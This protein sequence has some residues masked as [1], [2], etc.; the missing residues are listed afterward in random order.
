[1][2]TVSDHWKDVL[3]QRGVPDDKVSVV[4]NVADET[5]FSPRAKR[6]SDSE[7]RLIYHGNITHRY[8]LDLA[9][10]A[11]ALV[12]SDIPEIRLTILGDGDL[13]PQLFTLR[14]KL[15]L[16]QVVE[17]RD[18]FVPAEDLPEIIGRADAGIVPY[19]NDVFTDGLL[20]TKLM[21]YAVMALPSVAARTTAIERYFSGAMV[22]FF[23]PGDEQDLA[24]AIRVLHGNREYFLTLKSRSHNF[25]RRHNWETIGGRYVNL[26]EELG[27]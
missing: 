10:Q 21:E 14:R 18:E 3:V 26:I 2:I 9:L 1:V 8:G 20:P 13:M 5:I 23:E 19:R 6:S 11:V 24:R 27:A 22:E 7:F 17:L 25:V 16:E 12:Q 4:M 15:G